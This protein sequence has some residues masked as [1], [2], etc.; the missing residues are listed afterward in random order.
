M[1]KRTFYT[2]ISYTIG[3]V[4]LSLAT[5]LTE[6]AGFGVSMVVAPAYL[7]HLRLSPVFPSF[8]FGIAEY[9]FQAFLLLLTVI[10]L[11][12]FRLSYLFSFVT[13]LI[14]GAFL[15]LFISMI[16]HIPHESISTRIIFFVSGVIICS[17]S[18]ALLFRTYIPPEVYE[19]FVKEVSQKHGFNLSR[20][21]TIYD[22]SSCLLGII[23]SFVFFGFG[24]FEGIGIGTVLCAI[25][26]GP[27]IGLF[28]KL[29]E[30]RFE[31]K[32]RFKLRKFFE[33]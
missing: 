18:V 11:K 31:F 28:G 24:R 21:K 1:K 9:V 27:L 16:E 10:L 3:V 5:A 29:F 7:I 13:A 33:N 23:L 22:C 8:T 20:F 26:N 19:L 12:R 30:K 17:F 4:L 15:D 25:L 14:Y 2:E 32:D 6:A